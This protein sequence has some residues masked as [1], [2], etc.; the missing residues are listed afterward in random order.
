MK[1]TK[2]LESTDLKVTLETTIGTDYRFSI[3]TSVRHQIP[4][5]EPIIVSITKKEV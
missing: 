5:N 4:A 2:I 3:P 1:R